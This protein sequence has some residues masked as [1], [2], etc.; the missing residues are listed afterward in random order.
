MNIGIA[1]ELDQFFE[2]MSSE[3]QRFRQDQ[4][5]VWILVNSAY[6]TANTV[7]NA[8]QTNSNLDI[9]CVHRTMMLATVLDYQMDSFFLIVRR[10]LDAGIALLRLASELARDI[11]RVAQDDSQM[12]LWLRRTEKDSRNRYRKEFKFDLGDPIECHVHKLYDLASD[13]GVHGHMTTTGAL[14][15][16]DSLPD[17]RHLVLAVPDTEVYK[18]LEIW[19]G[20]FYPVQFMCIRSFS[21]LADPRLKEAIRLFMDGW[22]VFDGAFAVFRDSLAEMKA[23]VLS[24]LH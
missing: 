10:R 5:G 20:A 2:H 12:S 7:L 15:P 9:P 8:V 3:I 17:R 18:A 4:E 6:L 16:V 13:F 19:L 1:P 22:K 24:S 21:A 11:A 14:R 23:D